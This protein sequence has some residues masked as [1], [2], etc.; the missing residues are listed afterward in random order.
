MQLAYSKVLNLVKVTFLD[1]GFVLGD[2]ERSAFLRP[3]TTYC[4]SKKEKEKKKHGRDV[5]LFKIHP[6]NSDR[7][8]K[9]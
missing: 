2:A 6:I 4:R 3:L 9:R 8:I 7:P 1:N 5:N